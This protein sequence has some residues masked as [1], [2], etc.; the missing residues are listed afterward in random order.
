MDEPSDGVNADHSEKPKH[1][2]NN[3]NCYK[4]RID[5]LNSNGTPIVT[6]KPPRY[7]Q[8]DRYASMCS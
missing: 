7:Y 4:H 3:C 2:K 1:E 5:G 6:Y 8:N